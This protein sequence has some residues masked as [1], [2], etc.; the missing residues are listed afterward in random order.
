MQAPSRRRPGETAFALLLAGFSAFLVYSAYGIAGFEALSSPGALPMAAA[1]TMLVAAGAIVVQT[2]R[3]PASAGETVARDVLP[4]NI[5][6]TMVLVAGYGLLLQPLGFLP[7]SFL[8][9]VILMRVLGGQ[10]LFL[11][12]G[13]SAVS[14]LAIYVVFRLIFT[15]L[16]PEG[17]VPEREILAWIG[18]LF[19]G[20]R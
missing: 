12:A 8:F 16:M 15:V 6:I 5:V 10:S 1:G 4:L 14:V 9:L 7:T 13:I 17:I 19:R 18:N 20:G 11:C 3:R 2:L